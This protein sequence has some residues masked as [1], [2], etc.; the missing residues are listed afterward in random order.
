MSYKAFI[1]YCHSADKELAAAIQGA[2]QSFAKPWYRKYSMLLFR[3]ETGIAANPELWPTIEEALKDS[4]NLIVIASP[5]AAKSRWVSK[6]ITW[7][8]DNKSTKSLFVVLSDGIIEWKP[9]ANDFDWGKTTALPKEILEKRLQHGPRYVN[10]SWARTKQ[11]SLRKDPRF[12]DAILDLAVPLLGKSKDHLDKEERRQHERNM[13]WAWSAGI[14]VTA[15][16]AFGTYKTWDAWEKGKFADS[17]RLAALSESLRTQQANLLPQSALVAIEAA[18]RKP[19]L[20]ADDALYRSLALLGPKPTA[21]RSYHGL[22]DVVLSPRG[23]YV[24]QIPYDGPAIFEDPLSGKTVASLI[25]SQPDGTAALAIRQVSFN[26]DENRVATL[27]SLGMSAAVWELPGSQKLFQTPANRGA[28]MSIALSGDGRRLATGHT[29]GMIEVWDVASDAELLRFSHQD[30]PVEM[31]LSPDGRF[32]AV[33]SSRGLHGGYPLANTVRLWDIENNH[34]VAQLP[35]ASA[36]TKLIFSPN[37]KYLATTTRVGEDQKQEERIGWIK[38]WDAETGQEISSL[39]FEKVVNS[40]AFTSDGK[41]LLTG[42]SDD[43]GRLWEVASGKEVMVVDHGDAVDLAKG[44]EINKIPY[45]ATAGR[46]GVVRLWGLQTPTQGYLRLLESPNVLALAQN[47]EGGYL[48][49]ISH[50]LVAD[51][52]I[53]DA[54]Q[55]QKHSE[56]KEA[57]PAMP[58]YRRDL[59]VWSM[60]SLGETLPLAYENKVV[61]LRFTPDGRYL[62]SFDTQLPTSKLIPRTAS[63][64]PR[65]EY[66]DMGVGGVGL[67]E[68]ATHKKLA[69]LKHPGTVMSFDLGRDDGKHLITA[70]V[71]G[72]ARVWEI[73]SGKELASLK[74]LDGWVFEVAMSPDGRLAA[75]SAGSPEA[76]GGQPGNAVLVL[77]DWQSGREGARLTGDQA[78]VSLA[79]SADG[80]LL[81]GGGQD[82]VVHVVRTTDGQEIKQLRSENS[83]WT[84]AFSPDGKYVAGGSGGARSD[85][86]VLQQGETMLWDAKGGG[87]IDLEKKEEQHGSWVQSVAFSPDGKY[88]ASIDQDGLAM[89]WTMADKRK[90]ATLRHDEHAAEAKIHFSADSRYIVTAIG[91]KARVWEAATGREIARREHALGYLWEAA[92]S[93]D[94]KYLATAGTDMTASLWLWHPEDMINEACSRLPRN[95]T[96]EE[97]QQYIGHN[98]PYS[99]TCPNLGPKN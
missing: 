96:P 3:D 15:A 63:S 64:A 75:V 42:S 74:K 88:L 38:L 32:L 13:L 66:S 24:V 83:I 37:G 78:I 2:L 73:P 44:V 65:M 12:R 39:R 10:L 4:L 95:L 81:A 46:E 45:L 21:Q 17:H 72:I 53:A 57:E 26:T 9:E 84:L 23:K 14:A 28:I 98:V 59:R 52:A 6:E 55:A 7:W 54:T 50:D 43:K 61:G 85:D 30:P 33:T 20:E 70:C 79:F 71:D 97:W 22:L 60:E 29:D 16:A 40:I 58:D 91:K 93:P 80:Q 86:A 51:A 77:W 76:L 56:P 62:A 25:N 34:E 90:I 99:A 5:E 36:V 48:A 69:Y 41:Y 89:V 94:G 49:S 31:R 82:G 47:K 18:Q 1:S 92:F 67:V 35:H 8:L 87:K 19:S 68:V 11:G 27:T